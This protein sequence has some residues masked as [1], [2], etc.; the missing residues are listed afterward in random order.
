MA[1]DALISDLATVYPPARLLTGNASLTSFESDGLVA[2]RARP[3]VVVLP[4]TQDEVVAAVRACH[5]HNVP[6]VARG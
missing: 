1:I 4:E 6:F 5:R 2:F 3:S